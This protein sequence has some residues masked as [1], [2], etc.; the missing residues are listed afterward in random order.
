M[1]ATAK[2][3]QVGGS[4]PPDS[5]SYVVRKADRELYQG[6]KAGEFCYVFNSRQTGKSSLRVRAMQKLQEEGISCAAIDL[7]EIGSK[8]V[9]AEQWY[10][11]FIKELIDGFQLKV[12][13]RAWLQE[14]NDLPPVQQFGEFIKSV[15]LVEIN[16]N[17]V[18][19]VDEID[20]AFRFNFKEDFFAAIRACYNRRVDEPKYNRLTFALLGVAKPSDLIEDKSRTPFN[21]GRAIELSG[22]KE[23]EVQ[24][25]EKGLRNKVC[26]SQA[27]LREVLRW[28]GGQ[29][30]LT[31]NLCNMIQESE[32]IPKGSEGTS[33]EELV[34]SRA[35]QNWEAQDEKQH[36]KTIRDRL[37]SKKGRARL[38]LNL[39]QQI[40]Q[41]GKIAA[42]GS[43]EQLELQLSGL[44]VKRNE[45][46]EAYN[47]IYKAVFSNEWVEESLA[48]LRPT[49][50]YHLGGSLPANS[51]SYVERQADRELYEGLK[52]GKFC[53]VL[54]SRQTGKS[55][56]GVRVMQ[57][58]KKED[59][60]CASIDMR[61]IG[62]LG[63]TPARWYGDIIQ[64][65]RD[66]FQLKVNL[67]AWLQEHKDRSPVQQFGDFI[68]SVL[69]EEISKNIVIFLD[70]I[71]SV[72][73]VEF[74]KDF[75]ASIRGCY[76]RRY[77]KQQY[78]RLTFALLG[79]DR[80]SDL[81]D[82]KSPT[83]FNIGRAIELP[84]FQLHEAKLLEKGLQKNVGDPE[85]V[86]KEVLEWT[87]GQPFLTQKLCQLIQESEEIPKGSETA[88]VAA[89]V[90]SRVLKNLEFQEDIENLRTI[91]DRLLSNKGR[92][93][94]ILRAY[95]QI[96]Q[97]GKISA[98]DSPE[99]LELQLL[100]LVVKRDGALEADNRIYKAI[101]NRDWVEKTLGDLLP[102]YQVGGSLP[103]DSPSYV[104][105]QAD[106]ELYEGLK[107]GEF[108][109][110]FNSRQTGK[111]SL[112]V[113]VMQKL[114]GEGISC[115]T[116]DLTEIGRDE[117]KP[118]QWYWGFI[119]ELSG[120]FQLKVN[121]G[122]W[123]QEHKDLSPVQQFG[124]FIKSVLLEKI[125]QNI[126]IF[127]DEIDSVLRFNFKDD[128]FAAIR[129]CY[130][131]RV[132]EPKY[133]RLTFAL[134]GVAQPSDLIDDKSRT[135]FNIGRAIELPGFQLHE[136]QSL[137]EGLRKKV[138]DPEAVLREVLEWTGGQPFLTQKLCQLIQES[139][140]ILKGSEPASVEALVKSQVFKDW[141]KQEDPKHLRTIRDRLIENH[142]CDPFWLLHNYRQI[143]QHKEVEAKNSREQLEL[144]DSGLVVQRDRSLRVA[145]RIY[146]SV[147]N[148]DWLERASD[149][150]RPY[151]KNIVTW[152]DS[153]CQDKDQL[154]PRGNL[155]L[156][157]KWADDREILKDDEHKFLIDSLVWSL[158]EVKNISDREKEQVSEFLQEFRL[159]L[160]GMASQPYAVIREV[161]D[162]TDF[163]LSLTQKLCQLI[164]SESKIPAG[165]EAKR[166]E[167]LVETHLS[168]NAT[169][170]QKKARLYD[171]L[172]KANEQL[173]S[174]SRAL[175][176][177]LEERT[178]ELSEHNLE[179]IQALQDLQRTQAQ[180]IQNEKMSSLGQMVAG[181]SYEIN[182]PVSFIY[183]NISHVREYFQELLDL[184]NTYQEE[185]PNPTARI[186]SEIEKID[187]EFTMQD[188]P[189]LLNSM[190]VGV[191]RIRDIIL[192]LRNFSRLDESS[193]K[194]V[195]IHEGIE[196]TL[197][198]LQHRLLS[199]ELIK[200]YGELPLVTCYPAQLNQ[201]FMNIIR[202][203]IDALNNSASP[204]IIIRTSVTGND[205]VK[206]AIAD[207]GPGMSKVLKMRI[208]DPFFTTKPV[209]KGT[210]LGLSIS[211]SIVVDKHGGSLT[212]ISALEQGAEFI[213]E[214][215]IR[216]KT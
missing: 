6:L 125:S 116:I 204:Q 9:T 32:G 172:K 176:V 28:T 130:N 44:V 151:A 86:L 104:E 183:G 211:Y 51:P 48:K 170:S 55:S 76:D 144:V 185:Y 134:F 8:D 164:A 212:C 201:V 180:I 53:Y 91:P 203:A 49:P 148:Q 194:R 10:R 192:S 17:I 41:E 119:K 20:S 216:P 88:S 72:F 109:Y 90:H 27:V 138:D 208:Y 106:R 30:F 169:I 102:R 126:V 122:A 174:Y 207:N 82:D 157:L 128:F 160:Q 131:R 40:L 46:L 12:N 159:K 16:Q 89:L 57:K 111:S 84:G 171:R 189:Q 35:I 143:L 14:H 7:T 92:A 74:K 108:C 145:N 168:E 31:Q 95:Q 1:S 47:R 23:D 205:T 64:E 25:L 80:Q 210:G 63:V 133:N 195:D 18:I 15:L 136:A 179:L 22:F 191:E 127:V 50:I 196:S 103:P 177:K 87:G 94:Q 140:G 81:I 152:L 52:A 45:A 121:W 162:W 146:E 43:P 149:P 78:K 156:A 124:E 59:I 105:R 77:E 137:R 37:L 199:I 181:I 71:D 39:Y 193:M 113:R 101:F 67:P 5:P 56:L 99:Q 62:S 79:V 187:L 141:E 2:I 33:V 115:A 197:L 206:I 3:Y 213:I 147:F 54:N 202:N 21:I 186:Q 178:Q 135:P 93:R 110:V 161:R 182:N 155:Q 100:G 58:L 117:V 190:N 73:S 60:S 184:I 175:E 209:G 214:I 150:L 38:L 26:D 98:D 4:L 24:P 70:E 139:E 153:N 96:L 65:L 85:A 154:L 166:V 158:S 123:L 19:F 129:A 173:E 120:D 163:Q 132:D 34:Q 68:K 66:N 97:E 83:P 114:K 42:D 69:L 165:E 188:L 118:E 198:I 112:R 167:G 11:G 61:K 36:L 13:R 29:P 142:H 215:P 75:L 107:A 200:K